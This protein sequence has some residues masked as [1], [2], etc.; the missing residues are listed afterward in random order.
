MIALG[1]YEQTH[2]KAPEAVSQYGRAL[3]ASQDSNSR[4]IALSDL[5]SAYL[6]MG[7]AERAETSYTSALQQNPDND[8]ALV[9]SGLLAEREGDYALAVER[10]SRAVQVEPSDVGYLLLEQ[11]LRRA[12]RSAEADDSRAR[13]QRISHDFAQAWRSAGQALAAAGI[14]PE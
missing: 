12:G 1:V 5:A 8:A 13:A 10:I 14:N 2:G 6:Q 7:D 4:A 9:G 3:G 11:A